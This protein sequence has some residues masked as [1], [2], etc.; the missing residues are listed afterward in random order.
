MDEPSTLRWGWWCCIKRDSSRRSFFWQMM[1]A[2][3]SDCLKLKRCLGLANKC[4]QIS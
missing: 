1:L 3:I 4:L 2:N